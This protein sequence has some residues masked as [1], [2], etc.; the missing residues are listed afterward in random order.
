FLQG[1]NQLVGHGWP[2]TPESVDY[3]GWRFYAAAVFDDRN[4]WWIVMPDIAL[5]LQRISFLLRQGQ[6][7]NDIA[8]YLPNDDAWAHFSAGHIHMIETLRDL[9]G[10]DIVARLLDSG[11]NFDF[12]DDD[13]LRQVGRIEKDALVLGPN[14]YRVVVL[15]GVERIPLD[16]LRKLEEVARNGGILIATRHIPDA[17]P[18]LLSSEEEQNQIRTLSRSLFQGAS[19][20][21]RFVQNE[22]TELPGV[23]NRL[24]RPDVRLSPET[25][26]IGFVHR[27]TRDAEIYFLANT[28]NLRQTVTATFR[29]KGMNAQWWDP[30]SGRTSPARSQSNLQDEVSIPLDLEPYGSGVLVFTSDAALA[31]QKEKAQPVPPP[32]DVSTGWRVTFAQ[33]KPVMM[34]HLRSWTDDPATRY[35]SGLAT[36]EKQVTVP[37]SMLHEGVTLQ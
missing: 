25:P 33:S 15:P 2:Y 34:E 21:A 23:L 19:P 24:L 20:S 26:G 29:I 37:D 36:Y 16:T 4:P 30:F 10:P 17:A 5:Y 27:R 8:V 7:A 28:S 31:P 3:P 12:F 35:F 6:P 14:R 11:Y 32:L 13:A 22:N 18:G 9:I 1:I